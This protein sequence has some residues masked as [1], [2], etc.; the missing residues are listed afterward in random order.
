MP[1]WSKH[2]HIEVIYDQLYNTL[3]LTIFF[4]QVST[5]FYNFIW[6]LPFSLTVLMFGID[7]GKFTAIMFIDL[8]IAFDTTI[9]FF[10]KCIITGWT[11]SN[12]NG[13]ASISII[14]V[15]AAG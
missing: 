13:S 12:I 6:L 7:Q 9:F 4:T 11:V 5:A 10:T 1:G 15:S 2:P 8:E 3:I 14:A